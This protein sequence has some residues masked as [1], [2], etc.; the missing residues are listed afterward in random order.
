M[1]EMPLIKPLMKKV[2]AQ[3][4]RKCKMVGVEQDNGKTQEKASVLI[5]SGK[6]IYESM[7]IIEYIKEIWPHN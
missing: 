3:E 7:I 2:E 1:S 5:H 4:K 6:P